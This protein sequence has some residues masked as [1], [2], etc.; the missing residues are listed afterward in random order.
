VKADRYRRSPSTFTRTV[1]LLLAGLLVAASVPVAGQTITFGAKRKDAYSFFFKG[2]A[3]ALA[4]QVAKVQKRFKKDRRALRTVPGPDG[5]PAYSQQEV[6]GLIARTGEDLDQAIE[7]VRESGMEP[8]RAWAAEEVRR[9]QEELAASSGQS[10]AAFP[11][12][13]TPRVAA[14]VASLGGLPLPGLPGVN[15]AAPRQDTMTAEKSNL[16]LDQVGEVVGRI[17]L[18]AKKDDLEVNLWVG[19]TPAPQAQFRFWPQ[20]KVKGSAPAAIVIQ[21]ASKREHVLRGLYSYRATW[22]EGPVTEFIAY[23][24]AADAPDNSERLDLVG[25]SSF[26]CCRFNKQYCHHVANE[27]EC[28]P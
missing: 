24:N 26:F 22:G 18:L 23:P 21:T 7:R 3:W 28:R 20:G 27:K 14:V 15:A 8:L 17:F 13:A 10:A 12:R 16:L 1:A 2:L 9:I 19:S 4:V 6:A 11:R 5:Q 25:D